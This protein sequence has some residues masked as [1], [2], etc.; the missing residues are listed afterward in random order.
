[1]FCSG[2]RQAYCAAQVRTRDWSRATISTCPTQTRERVMYEVD[3]GRTM[4][5]AED[6]VF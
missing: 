3:G 4:G 5:M 2:L 6:H 1:M